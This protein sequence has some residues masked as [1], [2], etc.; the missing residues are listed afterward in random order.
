MFNYYMNVII[1][2]RTEID[3]PNIEDAIRLAFDN[4][5]KIIFIFDL[6]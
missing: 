1:K 2:P 6:T 3:L 4:N 5:E